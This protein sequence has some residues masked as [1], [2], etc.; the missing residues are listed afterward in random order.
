MVFRW[1]PFVV[2]QAHHERFGGERIAGVNGS[3]VNGLRAVWCLDGRAV[4]GFR[5]RWCSGARRS[6][7]DRLTT[8]GSGERFRRV[9]F[10]DVRFLVERHR[11]ERHRDERHLNGARR[12]WGFRMNIQSQATS[13]L[14]VRG[15]G[16]GVV[17]QA[18]RAPGRPLVAVRAV[19]W[20]V[21][22]VL[23]QAAGV[24][25]RGAARWR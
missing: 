11:D 25:R 18:S 3:G 23:A 4:G 7:F 22:G 17:R 19:R 5:A 15:A 24:R 12:G 2:R 10:R 13:D 1:S 6:W 9:R 16:A 14:V 20:L 21:A 8:N